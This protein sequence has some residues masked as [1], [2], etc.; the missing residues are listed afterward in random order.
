[1]S[2]F[3]ITIIN[4]GILT[5]KRD[6]DSS[7]FEKFRSIKKMSEIKLGVYCYLVEI[8]GIT[9]LL[10]SGKGDKFKENGFGKYSFNDNRSVRKTLLNSGIDPESISCVINTHLHF[11]HCGGNTFIEDEEIV[12]SFPNAKYF[13]QKKEYEYA[14]KRA[15][16]TN[17]YLVENFEPVEEANL[18]E[19]I[20]GDYKLGEEIFLRFCGGHTPGLMIVSIRYKDRYYHF[21]AD[22]LPTRHHIRL[23]SPAGVDVDPQKLKQFK[24][25]FLSEIADRGDLLFFYHSNQPECGMVINKEGKFVYRRESIGENPFIKVIGENL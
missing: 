4:D 15:P 24:N 22:L 12:P 5:V 23:N 25:K 11:D 14:K 9:F 21:T 10:D 6:P 8:D 13:V 16:F 19:I 2:S 20:D 7:L 17:S 18:L 1:M 3:S